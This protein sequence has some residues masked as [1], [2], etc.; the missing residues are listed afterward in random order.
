MGEGEHHTDK[1][2][3]FDLKHG[4]PSRSSVHSEGL[5]ERLSLTIRE[6]MIAWHSRAARSTKFLISE[7]E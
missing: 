4:D 5:I 6:A 7:F 3:R 2:D 1:Y